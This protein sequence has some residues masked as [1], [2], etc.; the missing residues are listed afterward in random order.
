MSLLVAIFAISS[1]SNTNRIVNQ[2]VTD[3]AQIQSVL[4]QKNF[5]FVAESVLPLRGSLRMLNERYGLQVKGDTLISDLP[6]FGRAR[7]APMNPSD[8]GVHF[9]SMQYN[10][11]IS[12]K[13]NKSWNIVIKP[14]DHND[15]RQMILQVFDNG[16]ATLN[17]TQNSK[18][19]IS[20]N[21]YIRANTQ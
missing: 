5:T 9:T 2:R 15:V 7:T 11:D 1:C 18:D 13:G 16:K 3:A 12:Q 17:V 4:E 20:Y 8:A 19:A 21:G 10:Y 6:Y 14:L